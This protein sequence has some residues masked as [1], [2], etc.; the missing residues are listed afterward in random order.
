[1]SKIFERGDIVRVNLNPTEG[2]EQKGDARPALVIS[3]KAF[4]TLGLT[5][6]VPITQGGEFARYAGFAVPLMGL[7]CE[8]QGVVLVNMV[9]SVDLQ[10]RKTKFVEKVGPEIVDEVVAR[11]LPIIEG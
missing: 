4:N 11:L 6:I 1:M 2:K 10:A 7:G 3:Q 9:R 8:T 5:M